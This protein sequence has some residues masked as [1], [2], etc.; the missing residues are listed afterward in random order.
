VNHDA[1]L[2]VG[3]YP[4]IPVAASAV[5]VEAVR[6]AWAAGDAVT[7]ASPR[8]SAA[9]LAVPVV[10]LLAG[11]RLRNLRAHTSARQLV[12]VLERGVPVPATGRWGLTARLVQWQ[13]VNGILR[14]SAGFNR[15][16][17]I[18]VGPLD[19]PA[20]I[21]ARL[22]QGADEVVAVAGDTALAATGVTPL[23]PL[24]VR[25]LE[26]PRQIA[27]RVARAALGR[28]ARPIRARIRTVSR[29]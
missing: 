26:R 29:R 22:L 8:L 25:L 7:V 9:H 18:R 27:E 28:Y 23:G 6:R 15:V 2:I 17:M 10:G 5:T 16:T 19:V 3:S 1:V 21:E 11:R 13:T 4:P 24:E 20:W 14:A 12:L